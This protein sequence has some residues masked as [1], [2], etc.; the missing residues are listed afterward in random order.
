[1][2]PTHY[3]KDENGR[4]VDR[5]LAGATVPGMSTGRVLYPSSYRRDED[6]NWVRPWVKGG[7][8]FK[9]KD[10]VAPKPKDPR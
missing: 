6:G 8:P 3:V 1:M 4:W 7:T 5:R 10:P 2:Y 9:S